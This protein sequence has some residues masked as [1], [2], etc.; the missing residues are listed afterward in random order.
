[1]WGSGAGAGTGVGVAGAAVAVAAVVIAVVD[2]VL[3]VPDCF[4]EVLSMLCNC[5][6][7]MVRMGS[8]GMGSIGLG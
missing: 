6:G 2:M 7:R 5:P 1:M 8:T 3:I 4:F